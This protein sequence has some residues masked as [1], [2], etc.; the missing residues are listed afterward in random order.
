MA[1][2]DPS[3]GQCPC[4]AGAG[5]RTCSQCQDGYYRNQSSGR[6][7]PCGCSPGGAVSASCNVSSGQCSCRTGVGGEVDGRTVCDRLLPAFFCPALDHIISE[8]EQGTLLG[9][10][11]DI[12][13]GSLY[14][15]TGQLRLTTGDHF[16]SA[17]IAVPVSGHYQ[18]VFRYATDSASELAYLDFSIAQVGVAQ[19]D[20]THFPCDPLSSQVGSVCLLE[21]GSGRAVRAPEPLCL[22]EGA[23][24]Q[25]NISA[26]RVWGSVLLDSLLLLPDLSALDVFRP[27]A[28]LQGFLQDG[29][30][31]G[32]L[33][34]SSREA[35]L[36]GQCAQLTCAASLELLDGALGKDSPP[37]LLLVTSPP[38]PPPPPSLQLQ[39][40]RFDRQL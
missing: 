9:R 13:A 40:W 15:G 31:A 17:D 16:T 4:L 2:C 18:V 20:P 32:Q 12:V 27:P 21:R 1:S 34:L 10:A 36:Q 24:Y 29:C 23:R 8:A 39:C 22:V 26:G 28:A 38:P 5:G 11:R 7:L 6:C 35:T 19:P 14:T 37:P 33:A 25:V 3:S 30:L